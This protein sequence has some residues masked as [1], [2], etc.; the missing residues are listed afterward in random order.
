ML[1][2]L[3]HPPPKECTMFYP[4]PKKEC[5]F[6]REWG[7]LYQRACNIFWSKRTATWII[8]GI[9]NCTFCQHYKGVDLFKNKTDSAL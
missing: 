8:F 1:G 2:L 6:Y 7:F 5:E 9:D 4:C 3:E